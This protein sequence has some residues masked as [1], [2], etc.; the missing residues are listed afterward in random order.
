M[1]LTHTANQPAISS[2]PRLLTGIPRPAPRIVGIDLAASAARRTG[3]ALLE[4]D[5]A[6]SAP[7]QTTE[8][9]V[10]RTLP[11]GR[12]CAHDDCACRRFGITRLAER[13]LR[14]RG[15]GVFWCLLPSMQ[16]LTLRG[17]DLA[18]T[19]RAHG[20]SVLEVYPG[21][22]QDLL[23]IGRKRAGLAQLHA[24]LACFGVRGM[25]NLP[26]ISHD[27][28]DAITSALVGVFYLAGH[29]E[30]VGSEA[31]GVIVLPIP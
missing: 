17:M 3:W 19:F 25:R 26:A 30:A 2:L 24:G 29:Y 27:E 4:G 13:E 22:A 23:G 11:A 1:L 12:D 15:I 14:R 28:L 7:L 20:L 5:Q 31:E 10:A 21:A 8:E 16:A 6:E 18:A 9:I